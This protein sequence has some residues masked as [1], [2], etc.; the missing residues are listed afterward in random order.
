MDENDQPQLTRKQIALL[1]A[2]KHL[3]K[4]SASKRSVAAVLWMR[5]MTPCLTS[6]F[7]KVSGRA[8]VLL[9]QNSILRVKGNKFNVDETLATGLAQ[10]VYDCLANGQHFGLPEENK[11]HKLL[12]HLWNGVWS[13]INDSLAGSLADFLSRAKEAADGYT[14]SCLTSHCKGLNNWYEV[15]ECCALPEADEALCAWSGTPND[16]ENTDWTKTLKAIDRVAQ[17]VPI[18]DEVPD[19]ATFCTLAALAEVTAGASGSPPDSEPPSTKRKLDWTT[20]TPATETGAEEQTIDFAALDFSNVAASSGLFTA[21]TS[22]TPIALAGCNISADHLDKCFTSKL[23][24]CHSWAKYIDIK[25]YSD[26]GSLLKCTDASKSWRLA[27]YRAK[28]VLGNPMHPALTRETLECLANLQRLLVL[29]G[30]AMGAKEECRDK[31][32]GR[33]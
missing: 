19:I 6:R 9:V 11:L 12:V 15:Y 5:Q 27:D 2:T 18:N 22:L 28:V 33:F 24:K 29:N 14:M 23:E 16:M 26:V 1:R 8:I 20:M 30:K 7:K 21:Q 3:L 31:N 4:Y 17:L 25:V 13:I 32:A 10:V